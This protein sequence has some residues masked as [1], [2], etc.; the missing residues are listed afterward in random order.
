MPYMNRHQYIYT[1]SVL[2]A[3]VST[4]CGC[5]RI[6]ETAFNHQTEALALN[7][8]YPSFDIEQTKAAGTVYADSL[9][10]YPFNA[11]TQTPVSPVKNDNRA[12]GIYYFTIPSDATDILFTTVSIHSPGLTVRSAMP[13]TLL[14]VVTEEGCSAGQDV[15]YGGITGYSGGGEEN[16]AMT[17]AVA[18]IQPALKLI[19]GED[20]VS[21]L[22][23]YFDSV[24]VAVSGVASGIVFGSDFSHSYNGSNTIHTDL[25]ITQTSCH[26]DYVYTFPTIDP[27]PE[28]E[29]RT[30]VSGSG[31][32]TFRAPLPSSLEAG[33]DY[34]ITIY[35]HK[36]NADV[37]FTLGDIIYSD[38]FIENNFYDDDFGLVT[39]SENTLL[40]PVEE[41]SS[42][43][44]VI[45]SRLG[46][47][48]T[49]L[50]S[51][52]LSAYSVENLSTGET[53]SGISPSLSGSSGDT[54]RFTTLRDLTGSNSSCL[55]VSFKAEENNTYP[56]TL[57]QSNG[58]TQKI[59]F[60]TS[61][62]NTIGVGGYCSIYRISGTDTTL[63]STYSDAYK[64][65]NYIDY[66]DYLIEGEHISYFYN[67]SYGIDEIAFE[68]CTS[69]IEL[70]IRNSSMAELDFNAMTALKKLSLSD[71]SELTNIN[72]SACQSLEYA[73]LSNLNALSTIN[74]NDNGLPRLTSL[75]I[76]NCD[77]LTELKLP[78]CSG[79]TTLELGC[80]SLADI[81]I[82]GC[83]SL[84]TLTSFATSDGGWKYIPLASIDISGCSSLK[85]FSVFLSNSTIER[86]DFSGCPELSK[87]QIHANRSSNS[88]YLKEINISG[89]N[90]INSLDFEYLRRLQVI[91]ASEA[92]VAEAYISNSDSLATLDFSSNARLNNLSVTGCNYIE[93]VDISGCSALKSFPN[94]L[95]SSLISLNL[96]KSGIEELNFYNESLNNLTRFRIDSSSLKRFT[97]SSYG[98]NSTIKQDS[99]NFS[100]C[101]SL[102]SVYIYSNGNETNT[103]TIVLDGCPS[104]GGVKIDGLTKFSDLSVKNAS[105]KRLYL[106]RCPGIS[107]LTLNNTD[108][109]KAYIGLD[110]AYMENLNYISFA[111]SKIEELRISDIEGLSR[112]SVAGCESLKHID[113]TD[114]Y[115]LYF[116][117]SEGCSNI[118]Y[119]K[120]WNNNES[121]SLPAFDLGQFPNLQYLQLNNMDSF[122]RLDLRPLTQLKFMNIANIP[123]SSI[124]CQ[125]L[126][127]L[128][129]IHLNQPS[130]P[131]SLILSGC[132]SLP[133][134]ELN[135]STI[136][137]INLDGTISLSDLSISNTNYLEELNLTLPAL[138]KL[139]LENMN[140]LRAIN[141]SEGSNI[142]K[143]TV[144]SCGNLDLGASNLN[145]KQ[146][147]KHLFLENTGTSLSDSTDIDLSSY[148]ALDT[149]VM[150]YYYKARSL[151]LSN[152]TSLRLIDLDYSKLSTLSVDGCE[153]LMQADLDHNLLEVDALNLFFEQ[154]PMRTID[155]PA[156]YRITNCPGSSSSSLNKSIADSKF[157]S[158]TSNNI[159]SDIRD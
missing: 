135:S 144:K 64:H 86:L 129:E 93:H 73:Y 34:T 59:T 85:E 150:R 37:G 148:T 102:D 152:C 128:S 100:G 53:A 47:W 90:N 10:A 82:N 110:G 56:L 98:I 143:V 70:D 13:D 52:V 11:G 130:N 145:G 118:T 103:T 122:K 139:Y 81:D 75:T 158:P 84:E 26:S 124:N 29:L 41:R 99:L 8:Q 65:Y 46:K 112:V 31:A 111:D 123:L 132:S 5:S 22:A 140:E 6:E 89:C 101:T 153:S 131:D 17:R 91:D 114:C 125:G 16:I 116:F 87:L 18:R 133:A 30:V 20:T 78:G 45:N 55:E 54:V 72:L 83:S 147:L 95:R 57:L 25:H 24:S 36:D 96:S 119:M 12:D 39:F 48:S 1:A 106:D 104:I 23:G 142:R 113:I 126:T 136:R 88:N 4:L 92:S 3:V 115:N 146:T 105:V 66:G 50:S 137:H 121:S 19:I 32:V 60:H 40:F 77:N 74:S 62:S 134:L 80:S 127:Q 35:L 159:G 42:R 97:Y 44:V 76:S 63:V 117:Y 7:V 38:D 21:N 43:D 151:N 67:E 109:K 71:N 14:S 149:L 156:E 120:L 68:N 51:E 107:T 15:L 28:V 58:V 108:I 138:E 141:I 157:W 33:K 69:L 155:S 94:V 49:N 27:N 9:F 79:L 61:N 154:L 2:L